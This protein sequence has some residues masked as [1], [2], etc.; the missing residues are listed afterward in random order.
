M[1]GPQP[2]G[3][4]AERAMRWRGVAFFLF[5]FSFLLSISSVQATTWS[6]ELPPD[7]YKKLDPFERAQYDKAAKLLKSASPA[8]SAGEFEKFKIQFPDSTQLS[9]A[10]FMRGYALQEA[11]QRNT[12]IKVYQEVLDYFGD[13]VD[14]AAPALYFMGVARLDNGDTL[15]GLQSMKGLVENKAYQHHPLAAGALRRLADNHWSN[16]EPDEAVKYWRQ[17]VRDFGQTNDTER[18][19]ATANLAAYAIINKDYAGFENFYLDDASRDKP[20][21]RR[22]IASTLCDRAQ[23]LWNQRNFDRKKVP[24]EKEMAEEVTAFNNWFKTTQPWWQKANDEWGYYERQIY[25]LTHYMTDKAQRDRSLDDSVGFIR[26]MP[27]KAQQNERFARL[28]DLC[29]EGRAFERARL[30]VG[31][32]SD[33]AYAMYKESEIL[34]SEGKWD[35]VA[36]KLES[37]E[38]SGN[39]FWADRAVNERARIYREVLNK[40]PEAIALYERINKPPGTLWGIQECYKRMN[41][42][43]QALGTLTEIENLFPT[44]ASRAAWQRA[45]YLNEAGEKKQAIAAARHVAIAYKA[46]P[47][48]GAAHTM[49]E[50][51]GIHLVGG[52]S[53]ARE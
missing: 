29:R 13:Q 51:F 43:P 11:K 19:L 42:L 18:D 30:L 37:V 4:T 31:Q 38:A 12:A 27:D 50:G 10:L 7:R 45:V 15:K 22:W 24:T 16:K 39:P 36:K 33:P 8:A 40:Q 5:T 32:M 41:K 2:L 25:V 47:E 52:E 6:W 46:A 3:A 35:A 34:G 9:Y 26:K 21:N 28:I 44:D 49:L 1:S 48:A 14:D 20:D 17:T 53:E 23:V